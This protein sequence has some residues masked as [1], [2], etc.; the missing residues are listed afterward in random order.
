M[1]RLVADALNKGI[2][3]RGRNHDGTVAASAPRARISATTACKRG[4]SRRARSAKSRS[5]SGVDKV[6]EIM[7]LGDAS[8]APDGRSNTPELSAVAQ[9]GEAYDRAAF[10]VCDVGPQF[11]QFVA[12]ARCSAD[13]SARVAP[14]FVACGTCATISS[15]AVRRGELI[16]L[17]LKA[18]ATDLERERESCLEASTNAAVALL[19]NTSKASHES[20]HNGRPQSE[21]VETRST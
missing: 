4:R 15:P 12:A 10:P 13:A 5:A 21:H 9:L 14:E 6:V 18:L 3:L 20:V 16:S 17:K 19:T 7:S 2:Q 1:Y 8:V 11:R